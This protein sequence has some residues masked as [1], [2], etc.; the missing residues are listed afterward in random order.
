MVRF[1]HIEYLYLLLGI[2]VFTILFILGLQMR[3]AALKRLG[4]I[5][6]LSRLIP[7]ASKEKVILKFIILNIAYVFLVIGIANPQT[8]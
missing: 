3:N 6:F 1:E 7:D 2:P 8:G 5:H 4:D